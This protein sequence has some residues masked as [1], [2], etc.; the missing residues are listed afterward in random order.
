MATICKNKTA[1]TITI[2]NEKY[3]YTNLTGRL[4]H[5]GLLA[6]HGSFKSFENLKELEK[7]KI[8]CSFSYNNL[9]P[10]TASI[11]SGKLLTDNIHYQ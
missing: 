11:K 8:A 1:R 3:I 6:H 9:H 2:T 7:F 4:K 5:S 10:S